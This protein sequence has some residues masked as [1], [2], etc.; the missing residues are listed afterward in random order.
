MPFDA[1]TTAIDGLVTGVLGYGVLIL[2]AVVALAL[3]IGNGA[4]L[5]RAARAERKRKP[6]RKTFRTRGK[7]AAHASHFA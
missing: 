4:M 2:V 5:V 3:I 1:S 6:R 7:E